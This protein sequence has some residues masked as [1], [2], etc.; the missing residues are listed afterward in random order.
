MSN[1]ASAETR[2]PTLYSLGGGTTATSRVNGGVTTA[3]ASAVIAKSSAVIVT[4]SP[5]G[6]DTPAA[7]TDPPTRTSATTR[8]SLPPFAV[9][10]VPLGGG[11]SAFVMPVRRD[12]RIR[13]ND[14][15]VVAETD[16]WQI[17]FLGVDEREKA[18][19]SYD[20]SLFERSRQS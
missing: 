9:T 17:F 14:K 16:R 2:S 18:P 15:C 11:I 6:L 19:K 3:R 4:V 10:A 8:L 12:L 13:Q 5:V 1:D 20:S 7:F